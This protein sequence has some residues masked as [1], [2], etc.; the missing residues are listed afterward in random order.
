MVHVVHYF[1]TTICN[2]VTNFI[3]IINIINYHYHQF[4]ASTNSSISVEF[5]STLYR[6]Q[7][8]SS[9]FQFMNQKYFINQPYR[10]LKS[11]GWK[12]CLTKMFLEATQSYTIYTVGLLWWR[13]FILF[14]DISQRCKS[15]HVT[16]DPGLWMPKW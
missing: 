7:V 11:W 2:F 6:I 3:I 1:F 15:H 8:L 16:S 12:T 14:E 13:V 10:K 4:E 9:L 5:S